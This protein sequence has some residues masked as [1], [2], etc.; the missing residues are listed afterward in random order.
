MNTSRRVAVIMGIDSAFGREL[1]R[2][3]NDYARRNGHWHLYFGHTPELVMLSSS[4]PWDVDGLIAYLG[5][6]DD[7][8]N[9]ERLGLP[10]V[11]IGSAYNDLSILSVR[12]DNYAIGQ[13]AA[14]HLISSGL[15]TFACVSLVNHA[16]ADDRVRGYREAVERALPQRNFAGAI[17]LEG[18]SPSPAHIP[19]LETF[20]RNLPVPCGLFVFN[21]RFAQPVLEAARRIA[22]R[23][24]DDLAL[25]SVDN[26]D[27]L[28][29]LSNPQ[30]SSV[31]S[32][33]DHVGF[34]AA[35]ELHNLMRGKKPPV[36]P[37]LIPHRG[38]I[39]RRSSDVLAVNDPIVAKALKYIRKEPPARLSIEAIVAGAAISRRTLER[40]FA[41]V[42]GRSVYDEIRQRRMQHA[43][44]LL[45][46]TT[47]SMERVG[48]ECGF[49]HLSHF[50]NAFA[51]VVGMRPARYQKMTRTIPDSNGA[52]SPKKMTAPHSPRSQ[53]R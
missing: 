18:R 23:I 40:R 11:N 10:A 1:L 27:L 39:T 22:M 28:C 30:L 34:Q 50:S 46:H 2:G 12:P 29:N 4:V 14:E 47:L 52:P 6:R 17:Q 41:Q 21:D 35:A 3:I 31:D 8:H 32:A 53:K 42:L 45:S 20:L 44:Y 7:Y 9:I 36:G 15:T 33:A 49:C 37:V 13:A 5:T 51:H 26:D 48:E 16:G 24:P 38:V 19:H 43:K 25:V